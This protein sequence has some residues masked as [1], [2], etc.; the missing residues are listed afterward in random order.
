MGEK[1]LMWAQWMFLTSQH[2]GRALSLGSGNPVLLT[3]TMSVSAATLKDFS[4]LTTACTATS[5]TSAAG[6]QVVFRTWFRTIA[7][8]LTQQK[9]M[10]M[11][12]Y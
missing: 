2:T 9:I 5:I 7:T 12:R 1:T 4:R 3:D 10:Y 6:V 11:K 8:H